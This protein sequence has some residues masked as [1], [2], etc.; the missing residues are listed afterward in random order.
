M[1]TF[2]T[3][4]LHADLAVLGPPSLDDVHAGHD[5]DPA[6]DGGPHGTGQVEDVVQ[7]A[8]D[9][10]AHPN[11]VGLRF[12]VD[13]GGAIPQ[14]LGDHEPHHLY[15]GCVLAHHNRLDAV[16]VLVLRVANLER[17]DLGGDA[18][19]RAIAL[20]DRHGDV[21]LRCDLHRHPPVDDLPQALHDARRRIGDGDHDTLIIGRE[22]YRGQRARHRLGHQRCCCRV[23]DDLAEIDDLQGLLVRQHV[24]EVALA[25]R[26]VG[27]QLAAQ[28]LSG[29]AHRLLEGCDDLVAGGQIRLDEQ[30]TQA[31]PTRLHVEV[32]RLDHLSGDRHSQRGGRGG[33]GRAY[34]GASPHAD[35]LDASADV[36]PRHWDRDWGSTRPCR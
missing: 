7:G 11:L 5:L 28:A 10:I 2:A 20:A 9:A 22:R 3:L 18:G 29:A 13:I 12:D 4:D 25:D 31:G 19:Q 17:L 6:D 24:C 21:R 8:V 16:L 26:T 36:T 27:D 23:G 35:T 14:A 32:Q 1:S 34:L 30:L 33:G 15:D